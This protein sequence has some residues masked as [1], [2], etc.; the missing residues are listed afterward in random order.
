MKE[1]NIRDNLLRIYSDACDDMQHASSTLKDYC[2][3]NNLSYD[4]AAHGSL[5]AS[6]D[7]LLRRYINQFFMANGELEGVRRVLEI[8]YTDMEIDMIHAGC[9]KKIQDLV[10]TRFFYDELP[11]EDEIESCEDDDK[12]SFDSTSQAL[13]GRHYEEINRSEK[14][15]EKSK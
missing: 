12:S 7:V 15:Y 5:K 1:S 4:D 2:D 8:F 13:Y 9:I 11:S 10:G 3:E 6:D 14:A